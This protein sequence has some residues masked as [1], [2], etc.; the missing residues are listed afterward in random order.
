MGVLIEHYGGVFP[1]WLAPVQ[2][3]IIPIAER[4]HDYARQVADE[5]GAGGLRAH[6]DERNERMNSK[7][8]D[9][10]M[11]KVP[12]MLIV[13]DRESAAGAAAVRLRSGENLGALP[14]AGIVSR[15]VEDVESKR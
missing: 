14:V 12:Y 9:A 5:L 1:T 7:I 3:E 4:H 11:N 8:R 2:A 15:I 13:G 10:Q 6:V